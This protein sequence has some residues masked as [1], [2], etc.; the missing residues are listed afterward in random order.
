MFL[1]V[2]AQI[3]K[4]LLLPRGGG[5]HFAGRYTHKVP[6]VKEKGAMFFTPTSCSTNGGTYFVR[7]LSVI[8]GFGRSIHEVL[9]KGAKK[10][11]VI[12]SISRF[13]QKI[14]TVIGTTLHKYTGGDKKKGP[15]GHTGAQG[16]GAAKGVEQHRKV[17]A[18]STYY[19]FIRGFHC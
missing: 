7:A 13:V 16:T 18:H 9:V 19:I 15:Y 2:K 10:D 6:M 5:M 3:T 12:G 4:A 14:V 11:G 8:T 17:N 1:Y